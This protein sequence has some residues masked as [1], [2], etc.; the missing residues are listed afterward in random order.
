ML[1]QNILLFQLSMSL[2]ETYYLIFVTPGS[3]TDPEATAPHPDP[4]PAGLYISHTHLSSNTPVSCFH[5]I[6]SVY[7]KCI[8]SSL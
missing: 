3:I 7:L 5:E 8:T 2:F 1:N 6:A 4:D